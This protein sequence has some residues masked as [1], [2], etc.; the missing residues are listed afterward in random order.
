MLI[1]RPVKGG[2]SMMTTA[3]IHGKCPRFTPVREVFASNFARRGD[4]RAAVFA[5]LEGQPVVGLW[6]GYANAAR[7]QLWEQH[8]AE[9]R[10][11]HRDSRPSL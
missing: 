9:H 10:L 8:S 2:G 7:T 6:G 4:V 5:Y 3:P 11:A 1:E